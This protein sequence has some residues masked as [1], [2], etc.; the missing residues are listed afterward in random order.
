MSRKTSD[1]EDKILKQRGLIRHKPAIDR[2]KR[3]APAKP[4]KTFDD[5]KNK[6]M[7]YV[8][9]KYGVR[10]ER[11]LMSGSLNVISK[12]IGNSVNRSTLGRWRSMLQLCYDKEHLPACEHCTYQEDMCSIGACAVLVKLGRS[13]LLAAKKSEICG[14]DDEILQLAGTDTMEARTKKATDIQQHTLPTI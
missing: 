11:L 3:L 1:I 7:R 4:F 8:E 5:M 12:A 13:D 9:M 10:L 2:P 6:N 14:D